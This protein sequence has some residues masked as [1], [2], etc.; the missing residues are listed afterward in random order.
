MLNDTKWLLYDPCFKYREMEASKSELEEEENALNQ[1]VSIDLQTY[2][3]Y[4]RVY[5]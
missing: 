5:C 2:S 3:M 1:K 4:V